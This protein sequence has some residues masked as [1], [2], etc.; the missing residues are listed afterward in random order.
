[1]DSRA[2]R[3]L[4]GPDIYELQA[5]LNG[6]PVPDVSV[7]C[8]N[9]LVRDGNGDIGEFSLRALANGKPSIPN[10]TESALEP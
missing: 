8:L 1:M 6:R 7:R 4:I 3:R 10:G 9:P 2:P 5:G